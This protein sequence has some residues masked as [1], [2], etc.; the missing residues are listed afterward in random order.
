MRI[1]RI[2]PNL[3]LRYRMHEAIPRG[4]RRRAV[5]RV[6]A[7]GIGVFLLLGILCCVV[8]QEP[9]QAQGG[10][11]RDYAIQRSQLK[12]GAAYRELQQAQYEAKLAEQDVLNAQE[13]NRTAQKHAEEVKRQLDAASKAFAAAKA[14]EAQARKA[15]DAA[16]GDVDQAFQ[17]PPAK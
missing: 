11:N 15:Y 6:V 8:G 14:K 17:K 1:A 9:A 7:S 5:Y 4:E 10:A 2:E 12:A 3:F 13:A 16:L